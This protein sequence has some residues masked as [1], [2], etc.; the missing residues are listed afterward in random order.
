[1]WIK[2]MD[3]GRV[4]E[5]TLFLFTGNVKNV[6]NSSKSCKIKKY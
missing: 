2:N 4:D 3:L 5:A 1:M 6:F